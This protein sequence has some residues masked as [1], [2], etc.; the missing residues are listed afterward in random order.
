MGCRMDPFHWGAVFQE[1]AA[2]QQVPFR[3]TS[4]T[5]KPA[6][7]WASHRLKTSFRHPATL[8]WG[9]PWSSGGSM[10]H[11]ESS[12]AA[13]G[14]SWSSPQPQCLKHFLH[15]LLHQPWCLQSFLCHIFSFFCAVTFTTVDW[16][17]F[18]LLSLMD[19]ALASA[20]TAV[21]VLG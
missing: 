9:P 17:F 16:V 18:L 10:L 19:T 4:P 7:A 20:S 1:Q 21:V 6:S 8:F 15:L 12:M 11:H 5:R 14:Q 2:P 3:V 13:G